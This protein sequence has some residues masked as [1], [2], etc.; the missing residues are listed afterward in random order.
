MFLSR[1]GFR[2][3]LHIQILLQIGRVDMAERE[4]QS[5]H[6]MDEDATLTQITT[7]WVQM[8]SNGE[9]LQEAHFIFQEMADKF[10]STVQLQNASATFHMIL[11]DFD[12]AE[13]ILNRAVNQNNN[14]ANSL[15]NM[16]T[17]LPHTGKSSDL[18]NRYENQLRSAT[19]HHSFVTS[20][21]K[22]SADFDRACE[23][24]AT[25]V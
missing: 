15:A 6:K 17:C 18:V 10:G 21:A 24:V 12:A 23:S 13:N 14:D 9:K 22:L 20:L 19:P 7:A 4:L 8:A 2:I 11:G 1:D 25:T 5:M 3:A 16:I